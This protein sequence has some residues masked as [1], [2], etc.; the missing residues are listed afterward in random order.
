MGVSMGKQREENP[1][2][3]IAVHDKGCLLPRAG[4]A[5]ERRPREESLTLPLTAAGIETV[6]L[7]GEVGDERLRLRRS[8]R[9]FRKAE[10]LDSSE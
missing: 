7:E 1:G 2:Q 5:R 8:G 4:R 6:S 3:I 10:S 9:T